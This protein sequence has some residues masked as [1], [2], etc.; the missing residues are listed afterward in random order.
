MDI[1]IAKIIR[2]TMKLDPNNITGEEY[3]TL[4]V[5]LKRDMFIK[6]ISIEE[7]KIVVI[8]EGKLNE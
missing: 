1:E 5:N 4:N 6:S 2:G 7:G 3:A 8:L